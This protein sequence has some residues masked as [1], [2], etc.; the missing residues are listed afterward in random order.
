MGM[1][2]RLRKLALTLH[3]ITSVGFP[4]A[5]ACF[6]ALSIVGLSSSNAQTMRAAYHAMELTTWIVILP[7]CFASLVSGFICSLGTPWGLFRYYW[8]IIKLL[9]SVPS[10]LILVVHMRPIQYMAEVANGM[11]A[12]GP[13]ARG[14]QIQLVAASA[15]ALGVL[16]VA[17][18]LSVYK[19]RGMTSYGMRK[20][21]ER[22]SGLI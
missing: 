3:V 2:P 4:G 16:L 21:G 9:I 22:A 12:P 7:L 20:A 18:V 15:I 17:T 6:L 11:G 14:V 1:P 10:T 8:I 19:P 5:V 13:E